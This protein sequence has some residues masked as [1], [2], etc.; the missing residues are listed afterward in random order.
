MKELYPRELCRTSLTE[1]CRGL[2]LEELQGRRSVEFHLPGDLQ[3]WRSCMNYAF[4]GPQAWRK[5]RIYT[6]K[7]FADMCK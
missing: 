2:H 1:I 6:W 4:G 7:V 3:D 5:V